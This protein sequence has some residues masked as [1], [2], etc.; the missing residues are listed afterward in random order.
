[1]SLFVIVYDRLFNQF[2]I[3]GQLS[4]FKYFSIKNNVTMSNPEHTS[5]FYKPQYNWRITNC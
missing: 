3:D 4:F 1:M 2:S 5:S